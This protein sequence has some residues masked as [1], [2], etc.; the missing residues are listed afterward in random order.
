MFPRS[1]LTLMLRR[2]ILSPEPYFLRVENTVSRSTRLLLMIFS[3]SSCESI[4]VFNRLPSASKMA[5]WDTPGVDAIFLN[6]SSISSF[7]ILGYP[8]LDLYKFFFSWIS[9]FRSSI[10]FSIFMFS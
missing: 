4:F 2:F 5:S 7:C 6:S 1:V 8:H 3:I 9:S 10:R